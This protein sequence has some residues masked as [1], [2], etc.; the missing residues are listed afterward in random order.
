MLVSVHVCAYLHCAFVCVNV[1][2]H[3]CSLQ[4]NG[5]M[6]TQRSAAEERVLGLD[7]GFQM[8]PRGNSSPSFVDVEISTPRDKR[9]LAFGTQRPRCLGRAKSYFQ[10]KQDPS[11][12]AEPG[13]SKTLFNSEG[14]CAVAAQQSRPRGLTGSVEPGH[15][16]CLWRRPGTHLLGTDGHTVLCGWGALGLREACRTWGRGM[17]RIRG[18]GRGVA[19]G[20]CGHQGRLLRMGV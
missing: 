20:D 16:G 6:C 17:H 14:M 2:T 9:T 7:S 3:E 5:T 10:G 4:M 13:A 8:V 11:C 1:F 12:A 19:P 18:G 15:G